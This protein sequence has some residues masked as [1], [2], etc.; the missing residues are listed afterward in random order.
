M[1]NHIKHKILINIG[2]MIYTFRLFVIGNRQWVRDEKLGTR[3]K[4]QEARVKGILYFPFV[5]FPIV[6]L[7]LFI[8]PLSLFG[9]NVG[10]GG[11]AGSF[12][13]MGLGARALAMGGAGTSISGDA[14]AIYYN[15]AGIAH[16]ENPNATT[17]L[18]NM[19]LDRRITFLGYAQSIS[20]K[21]GLL[22]GGFGVGWLSSSVD[23]IDARDFSGND[24]GSL[25]VGEHCFYFC[26]GLRPA[27]VLS[28]GIS[29]KLL[30]NRFPE[31]TQKDE[32]LS[33]VGFGFDMGFLLTPFSNLSIGFVVQDLRSR[34]TWDSQKMYERG[35]QTVD[36]FPKVLRVGLSYFISQYHILVSTDMQKIE[37]MPYLFHFGAQW[38]VIENAFLR[39]GLRDSN[40]TLGAGY[41][42]QVANHFFVLDYG[43]IPDSITPSPTHI[44]TCSFIL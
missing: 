36:Q 5:S 37:N 3:G 32:S 13:R 7:L 41:R 10:R 12:M 11:M 33:A 17:S 39:C 2:Q 25:S 20:N 1:F 42:F 19:S 35:T 34:Y 26:F 44:F 8:L 18:N 28:I 23:H 4:R 24:I 30:Y 22:Q 31:I 15:P 38:E 14:Y 9:Q 16:L 29:G 6:L 21:E 40:L 43:F 27:S